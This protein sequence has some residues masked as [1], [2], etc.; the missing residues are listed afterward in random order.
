VAKG[1]ELH[2]QPVGASGTPSNWSTWWLFDGGDDASS[3]RAADVKACLNEALEAVV[4]DRICLRPGTH[5]PVV[6]IITGDGKAM[7]AANFLE[8]GP[9]G[10]L[11][12]VR[13]WRTN[14]LLPS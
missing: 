5:V 14:Q 7:L 1:D 6:P 8:T 2:K 10:L 11:R 3:L 4:E 13:S 12:H 9:R